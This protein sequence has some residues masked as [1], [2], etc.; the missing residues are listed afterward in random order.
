MRSLAPTTATLPPPKPIQSRPSSTLE[1]VQ[2]QIEV[3]HPNS[4][5]NAET[6]RRPSTA[7]TIPHI[8][9]QISTSRSPHVLATENQTLEEDVFPVCQGG[10]QSAGNENVFSPAF[11]KDAELRAMQSVS[12]ESLTSQSPGRPGEQ[13]LAGNHG[14]RTPSYY[15]RM[16]RVHLRQ[17]HHQWNSLIVRRCVHAPRGFSSTE[18]RS[19]EQRK[20]YSS[21]I[22][23]QP[24]TPRVRKTLP[25]L[26]LTK[27]YCCIR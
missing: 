2:R 21:A 8:A 15:N 11:R 10:E 19:S 27:M 25:G 6:V 7:S 12:T 14:A 23:Q 13:D 16:N 20:R 3:D 22:A 4:N 26:L 17:R 9:N 1:C 24:Q 5:N 18:R